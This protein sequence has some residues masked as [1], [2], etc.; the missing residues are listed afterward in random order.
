M[1]IRLI[2]KRSAAGLVLEQYLKASHNGSRASGS[3]V[4]MLWMVSNVLIFSLASPAGAVLGGVGPAP[5][6]PNLFRPAG[7]TPRAGPPPRNVWGTARGSF[8][9]GRRAEA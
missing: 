1:D 3:R 2:M 7:N 9:G 5:I 8:R 4:M 6:S